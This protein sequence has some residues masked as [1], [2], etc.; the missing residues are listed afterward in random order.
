[1]NL[2]EEIVDGDEDLQPVEPI[3]AIAGL[4]DRGAMLVH[5]NTAGSACSRRK[6]RLVKGLLKRHHC[7]TMVAGARCVQVPAPVARSGI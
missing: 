1:M 4:D 2:L 3:E 6:R 5:T 7:Y